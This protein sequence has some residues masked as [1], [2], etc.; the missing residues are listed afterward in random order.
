VSVLLW[1]L[2]RDV[3]MAKVLAQLQ[4]LGASIQFLDQ[5]FVLE[6]ALELEVGELTRQHLRVGGEKFDLDAVGA[7]YLRPYDSTRQPFLQALDLSSAEHEHARAVDQG[8]NA[9]ADRTGA[10]VLNRPS[11][12][13]SNGS[14]PYQARIIAAAG[15]SIPRTLISTDPDQAGAFVAEHGDVIVKSVSGVRSRVWRLGPADLARLGDVLTCPTQFQA[16]VPGVDVRVHVVGHS[17]FA[18]EIGSSATDYRYAR[19]QGHPEPELTGIDLPDEVEQRCRTLA[20][21][22]G[23]PVA[24]IDLRRTPDG[25]WYC[26]EVNPSPGFSYYESET[27][28]P[29]A[30]AIA[31]LLVAADLCGPARPTVPST[32][33]GSGVSR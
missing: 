6:T 21:R 25:E 19:F 11:A 4:R 2:I 10:Y 26:F 14:K 24:G 1:G 5:R 30:A 22:L 18:T 29:I 27:G 3:P 9:W 28:Q 7:A 8:L 17:V 32:V 31:G 16:R 23:L 33:A 15:F 20:A 12:A 13:A